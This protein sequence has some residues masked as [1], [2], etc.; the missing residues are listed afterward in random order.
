MLNEQ[1]QHVAYIVRQALDHGLRT[2][3][4]SE[5][6]EAEWVDTILRLAGF[7]R[8]FLEQ[9]TPGYYNN[10]GKLSERAAQNGFFGGGSEA[11]F[12]LL[13]DWRAAGR[14]RR[15]RARLSSTPSE[16]E[17]VFRN[18]KSLF[19]NARSTFAAPIVAT[20][21][22]CKESFAGRSGARSL[23]AISP[24]LWEG[25]PMFRRVFASF[26]R[27]SRRSASRSPPKRSATPA[28]T[29]SATASRTSG[30]CARDLQLFRALPTLPGRFS[31]GP[32]WVEGLAAGLGF[33]TDGLEHRR[34]RLRRG[35]RHHHR[36]QELAGPPLSGER[37][38][39]SPARRRS[40]CCWPAATTASAA[41]IRSPRR[42]TWSRRSTT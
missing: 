33:S 11:F 9:C 20:Y 19:L 13:R 16:R 6:A 7:G 42:A 29:P 41:A 26:V 28:S 39:A 27:R 30:I 3:E 12:K 34:Q 36:R 15:P 2:L 32:V 18:G 1:S 23:L 31:N 37:P 21:W 24:D 35:R 10:E 8:Q 40:T 38:A 25:D 5:A 14:A 22:N 17:L 4:V